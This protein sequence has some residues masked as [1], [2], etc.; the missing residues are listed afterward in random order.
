[1]AISSAHKPKLVMNSTSGSRVSGIHEQP[2]DG[3][4]QCMEQV[5]FV[6]LW[7]CSVGKEYI[8]YEDWA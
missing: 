5:G 2:D 7:E 3:D 6:D 8:V 4:Q 1:M